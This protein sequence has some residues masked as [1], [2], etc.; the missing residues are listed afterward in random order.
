MTQDQ[1]PRI[2]RKTILS[3][4]WGNLTKYEF[5]LQRR[6]GEWQRLTREVYDRGHGATCLL[7]DPDHDC[8]L[9]TRQFRLPIFLSGGPAQAI[10]APAGL[11]EGE[12]PAKRMQAEL[13]E[14]TGYHI[15]QLTHLYDLYMSPGSVTEYLSYF[16]GTYAREN[17]Q[18]EGGGVVE[19]GED[20]E[21]IH[22]P[23]QKAMEMIKA[24]EIRDGKTVILLQH[25]A[26]SLR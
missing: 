3:D 15:S 6:T 2:Q 11:L 5:D 25:L 14:E 7:H 22:I 18:S 9:L 13:I 24:G 4:D 23:L 20:I 26:L 1:Y 8:V 17:R 16:I 10:E 12:E 19:E 21:T